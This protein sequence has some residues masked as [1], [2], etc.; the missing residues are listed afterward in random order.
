MLCRPTWNGI[1][2]RLYIYTEVAHTVRC[3]DGKRNLNLAHSSWKWSMIFWFRYCGESTS[4][5]GI[6]GATAVKKKRKQKA[7]RRPAKIHSIRPSVSAVIG[8]NSRLLPWVWSFI[9]NLDTCRAMVFY[10]EGLKPGVMTNSKSWVWQYSLPCC[11]LAD[12]RGYFLV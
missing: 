8:F 5:V 7:D 9:N 3:S 1:L 2:Y 10:I 11:M 6:P 12:C 4:F